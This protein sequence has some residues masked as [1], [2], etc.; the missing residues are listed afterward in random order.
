MKIASIVVGERSRRDMTKIEQLA[1]SIERVGLIQPPV[2][3][4][5]AGE[6]HLV[7]G[8]RR[9]AAMQ[10]LGWTE[11]RVT[12]AHDLTDEL[13]A[14]LAE[15]D[16]NTERE[17][18]TVAEAVEHRRRIRE[19]EARLAKERQRAAG[20]TSVAKREAN[21]S[22]NLDE[23]SAGAT[24]CPRCQQTACRCLPEVEK[25]HERTTRHRTAKATG[26]G[27]TTL[28]KAEHIV[29]VAEDPATPEP[30][31]EVAREAVANL[32]QHGVKVEA[33]RRRVDEALASHIE[34]DQSVQDA[35]YRRNVAKALTAAS[36][37]W[38]FEAERVA[39]V[40]DADLIE[41]IDNTVDQLGRWRD[42]IKRRRT[43]GLRVVQGGSK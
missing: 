14:L 25:P 20:P 7:C 26:Y 22:S 38:E 4:E 36:A 1:A 28:D 10:H 15:G 8:G 42:D 12:V 29:K 40:A 3:R 16:E 37:L 19:V 24:G 18:F 11:T 6:Y 39:D 2:V 41:S 32:S 5:V 21:G 31:R 9:L 23:P 33:E 27:A 34:G 43:G 35:K 30:V 17:P 13:V